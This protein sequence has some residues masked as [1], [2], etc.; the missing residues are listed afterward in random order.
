MILAERLVAIHHALDEAT[1]EH[2]IG[3]AIALAYWTLEPRGTRDIDVNVFVSPEEA[4]SVLDALPDGIAVNEAA[5]EAIRRDGQVRLWWEE[6]PVD[7][8]FSNLPIHDQAAQ[9]RKE[10]PF[11]GE[12]IPILAPL[13]LALFKA[14]FDRTRDWAD[15]EEMLRAHAFGPEE[16]EQLLA[17]HV[18]RDD[19]R[20]DRLKNAVRQADMDDRPE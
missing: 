3:G 9:H 1:I 12:K 6:T 10:V 2:A 20:L 16:L 14:M 8:F 17:D 4:E 18:G 13:E 7:L 11:E 5:R 19:G 15:I